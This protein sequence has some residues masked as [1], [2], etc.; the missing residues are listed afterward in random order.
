MFYR[1]FYSENPSFN[2]VISSAFLGVQHSFKG[3]FH[4]GKKDGIFASK[5]STVY[6]Y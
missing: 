3:Y 6:R 1:Y 2:R 4:A 5:G